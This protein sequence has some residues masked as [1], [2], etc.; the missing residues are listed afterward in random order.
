LQIYVL[1]SWSNQHSNSFGGGQWALQGPLQ[2]PAALE[3][4]VDAGEIAMAVGWGDAW[5]NQFNRFG[6]YRF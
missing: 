4:G 1:V 5:T 3:L 6:R 2:I